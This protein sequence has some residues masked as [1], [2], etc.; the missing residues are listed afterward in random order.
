MSTAAVTASDRA[1]QPDPMRAWAR[2]SATLNAVAVLIT[3]VFSLIQHGKTLALAF[4]NHDRK[5]GDNLIGRFFGT[6]IIDIIS[7]CM[8][9]GVMRSAALYKAPARRRAAGRTVPPTCLDLANTAEQTGASR[10]A[11]RVP[12]ARLGGSL[13]QFT[14]E[15]DRRKAPASRIEAPRFGAPPEHLR[16]D[17]LLAEEQSCDRAP[18]LQA[19]AECPSPAAGPCPETGETFERTETA[20]V[21][22]WPVS[23]AREVAAPASL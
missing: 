2:A 16:P 23:P 11:Q 17:C 7:K 3:L 12:I 8:R 18:P 9:R 4:R 10:D 15:V 13:T 5:P 6:A 14:A 22:H 19:S 20:P 21:L 1:A